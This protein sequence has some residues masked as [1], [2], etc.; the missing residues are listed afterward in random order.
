M[1]QDP[2]KP[3]P[4]P[5]AAA[6]PAPA[7]RATTTK[8]SLRLLLT[9]AACVLAVAVAG[10]GWKG[11][12]QQILQPTPASD[13]ASQPI[14]MEQI[15]AMTEKL[16]ERL[17]SRPDDLQGWTMLA[18]A[19]S[20]LD[21]PA[22][23]STAYA[24]A[25]SLHPDDAALLTDYADALA[26]NNSGDLSGQ[27]VQLLERALKL[28]PRQAKALYLLGTH[29]FNTRDY[30]KAIALWEQ[31]LTVAALDS[32]IAEQV[33]AA[34]AEARQLAAMPTAAT[35]PLAATSGGGG[36]SV[37]GS[38][39]GSVSL[40][41]ALRQQVKPDYTLFVFARK[42]PGTG[43]PLAILRKQVRDL[44]LTFQLDDS[45]AMSAANTLSSASQV[46][47]SARISKSGN[48]TPQPGDLFGQSAPVAPGAKGLQIEI[49]DVVQP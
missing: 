22:E 23:A 24:R 45:M 48:A 7:P 43:M 32:G 18:R 5:D 14:S 4:E 28:E 2:T 46:V 34:I 13:Y 42:A 35:K 6:A 31:L 27:P 15:A 3:L 44:P 10:Y 12:W 40:S 11:A 16:A 38:I 17:Q 39:Q 49:K 9:L 20:V 25:L 26:S 30:A 29:A 33:Q 47:V 19:Y 1:Q 21:R 36:S 8:P 41:A 37:Q